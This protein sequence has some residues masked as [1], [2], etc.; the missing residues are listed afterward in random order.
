MIRTNLTI[1]HY[2]SCLI[3]EALWLFSELSLMPPI[4]AFPTRMS[5]PPSNNVFPILTTTLTK[6]MPSLPTSLPNGTDTLPYRMASP[7]AHKRVPSLSAQNSP[8]SA[9]IVP[10]STTGLQ[11]NVKEVILTDLRF[12][13]W[14][15]SFYPED[16]VGRVCERLFVCKWCFRY[17]RD[18]AAFAQHTSVSSRMKSSDG[19]DFWS[20]ARHIGTGSWG[21]PY[22]SKTRSP[23]AKSMAPSR[24]PFPRTCHCLPNSFS[25]QSPSSSM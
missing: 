21:R 2:I 13:T 20:N 5:Q 16:L 12:D 9:R 7:T 1:S 6:T 11:R 17:S 8:S 25:I 4:S 14:Y 15:S 18:G 22:M 10:S 24:K 3:K 19:T 23:F